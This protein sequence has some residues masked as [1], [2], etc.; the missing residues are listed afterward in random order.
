MFYLLYMKCSVG[1]C[2]AVRVVIREYPG[3]IR[4]QINLLKYIT[5]NESIQGQHIYIKLREIVF[6]TVNLKAL[7]WLKYW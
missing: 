6:K 3:L 2:I 1:I 5:V 4:K 7:K